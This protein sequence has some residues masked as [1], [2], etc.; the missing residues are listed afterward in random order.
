MGFI[1]QL[2]KEFYKLHIKVKVNSKKQFLIESEQFLIV[3]VKAKP[4]KNRANKELISLLKNR[5]KITSSE[6]EIV[7]GTKSRSKVVQI[8]FKHEGGKKLILNR[9]LGDNFI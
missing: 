1:E 3:H 4:I 7:S 6:I 9:L 2:D 8:I 5:L